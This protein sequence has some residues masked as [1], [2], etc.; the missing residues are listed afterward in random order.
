MARNSEFYPGRKEKGNIAVIVVGVVLALFAVALILFYGMQQYAV[1]SKEDV[2]L[3]V[4]DLSTASDAAAELSEDVKEFSQVDCEIVYDAP[5]YSD[6]EATAGDGLDG[7]R[8]IFVPYGDFNTDKLNE[9]VGR[10]QAGNAL[11]LEM[12]PRDGY[13]MWNSEAPL[14]TTYGLAEP[15]YILPELPDL[16]AQYKEKDIYMVAQVSCLLDGILAARCSSVQIRTELGF[17]YHD[18]NGYW[19]CPYSMVV[20]EYIVQLINELYAM[21]FDEVVL[22]DVMHPVLEDESQKL[23]YTRTMAS[24]QNPL[25]G[26]SA[27][28]KYITD[29]IAGHEGRLS[30]YCNSSNA[31]VNG[32]DSSNGQD[33]GLFFK[34]FDRVYYFTDMYAYQ[35]VVDYAKP[36]I[37]KGT[38][39]DRFVPVVYNYLPDNTS[40][41]LVDYEEKD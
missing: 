15:G 14:A 22:A 35:Y 32:K 1:I 17:D 10:L 33:V 41:V 34:M 38:V 28:V 13:L 8:A 26:I 24:S 40:W 6:I 20:R 23:I 7:V 27:F 16:I 39:K 36:Y 5:D 29:N 31:L 11:V 12:K 19:L 30:I 18:D 9:Y 25:F 37:K 4:G 3:K 2:Y 21:G